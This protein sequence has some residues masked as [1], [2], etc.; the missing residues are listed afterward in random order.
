MVMLS[1]SSIHFQLIHS[2]QGPFNSTLWFFSCHVHAVYLLG[3]IN[4]PWQPSGS[5][6]PVVIT[7]AIIKLK[8]NAPL[9]A[10]F[11]VFFNSSSSLPFPLTFR[12]IVANNHHPCHTW[13]NSP[14][15]SRRRSRR[16]SCHPLSP[17]VSFQWPSTQSRR[18]TRRP[19]WNHHQWLLL[20]LLTKRAVAWRSWLTLLRRCIAPTSRLSSEPHGENRVLQYQSLS[21]VG[22]REMGLGVG[23]SLARFFLVWADGIY[24]WVLT[25][26]H[27][28]SVLHFVLYQAGKWE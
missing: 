18:M 12:L 10:L 5:Q 4:L 20:L 25:V 16:R 1:I 17:A 8:L 14:T 13:P 21:L 27:H 11:L 7:S 3:Y 9:S 23:Y 15:E 6:V 19:W 22:E 2:P 26:F 28:Y 24:P